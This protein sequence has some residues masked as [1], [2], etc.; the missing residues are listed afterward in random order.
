MIQDLIFYK[1]YYLWVFESM[2]TEF[3]W[4]THDEPFNGH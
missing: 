3:L 2:I 4:F 1:D